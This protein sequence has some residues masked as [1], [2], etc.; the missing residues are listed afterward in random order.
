MRVLQG[1]VYG[2]RFLLELAALVGLGFWGVQTGTSPPAQIALGLAAPLFAAGVWGTFVAPKAPYRLP[3]L[4][5]LGL[6]LLLFGAV[7]LALVSVGRFTVAGTVAGLALVT[8]T[9]VFLLE[10]DG[11]EGP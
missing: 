5:R 7:A 6:E 2:V 8:S 3:G 10:R 4:P 9:V 1:V 11:T